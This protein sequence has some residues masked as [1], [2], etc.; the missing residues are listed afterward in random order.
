MKRTVKTTAQNVIVTLILTAAVAVVIVNSWGAPLSYI[1]T[2]VELVLLLHLTVSI[3]T[4]I[5]CEEGEDEFAVTSGFSPRRA[6]RISDIERL[7]RT[8]WAF[9]IVFRHGML[10]LPAV[11]MRGFTDF[12]H[13]A[14][15]STEIR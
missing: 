4:G 9:V 8:P 12:S 11:G 5:W 13:A 7:V 14:R 10:Y 3:R 1:L 15:V 6:Y 2:A